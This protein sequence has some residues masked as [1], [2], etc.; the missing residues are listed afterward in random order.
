MPAGGVYFM[1][2]SPTGSC[3][4]IGEW[5]EDR[6]NPYGDDDTHVSHGPAFVNDVCDDRISQRMVLQGDQGAF[7]GTLPVLNGM[8]QRFIINLY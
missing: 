7:F 8:S 6:P 2:G 3:L 4:E 1:S 5:T